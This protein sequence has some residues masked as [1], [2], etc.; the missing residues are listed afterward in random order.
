VP[1]V[2]GRGNQENLIEQPKNGARALRA[3]V[4]PPEANGAYRII[5][6]LAWSRKVWLALLPA[7]EFKRFLAEVMLL[8]C[9]L[10]RAGRRVLYRRLRWGPWVDLPC[11]AMGHVRQLRFP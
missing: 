3:P 10:V 4:N 2:N 8:P 1:F 9:Q 7:M 11:R 6:A 5:A